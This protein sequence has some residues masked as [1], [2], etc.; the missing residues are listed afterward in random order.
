MSEKLLT[1]DDLATRL[2]VKTSWLYQ[3]HR[4]LGLPA[5][6]LGNQLRFDPADVQ[7]FLEAAK[8]GRL[9]RQISVIETDSIRKAQKIHE[10]TNTNQQPSTGL[11][12]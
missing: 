10:V 3:N 11:D 2:S 12:H 7:A 8:S 5:I 9:K 6:K 4:S 1:V